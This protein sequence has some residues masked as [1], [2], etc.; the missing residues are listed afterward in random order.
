VNRSEAVESHNRQRDP[1]HAR[2]VVGWF[3]RM[4]RELGYTVTRMT[5]VYNET[6]GERSVRSQGGHVKL[7]VDECDVDV[8]TAIRILEAFTFDAEE[9]EDGITFVSSDVDKIVRAH[10]RRGHVT[11][12]GRAMLAC[13]DMLGPGWDE[14]SLTY[15]PGVITGEQRNALVAFMQACGHG[16]VAAQLWKLDKS[17]CLDAMIS[18]CSALVKGDRK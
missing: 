8:V 7:F 12:E 14:E 10:L 18:A 16:H 1:E 3:V 5:E 9:S 6:T 4:M 11:V 2:I 15:R 13:V 17:T